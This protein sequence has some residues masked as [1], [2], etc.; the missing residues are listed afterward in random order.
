METIL[1]IESYD[2]PEPTVAFLKIKGIT[3]KGYECIHRKE[4]RTQPL[5]GV[6]PQANNEG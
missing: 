6:A 1:E 4:E 5:W 2:K 3:K